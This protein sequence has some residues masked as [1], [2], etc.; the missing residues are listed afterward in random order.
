MPY[1]K[2]G[3]SHVTLPPSRIKRLVDGL[4]FSGPADPR[5]H[6]AD[7]QDARARSR[8]Q[9]QAGAPRWRR[10]HPK[11]R[12]AEAVLDRRR[13]LDQCKKTEMVAADAWHR[14][15]LDEAPHAGIRQKTGGRYRGA[16]NHQIPE[17]AAGC[18]CQQ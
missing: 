12:A 18:R 4:S 8:E 11:S 3:N 6:A 7:E 5:K 16:R 17:S 9:A 13:R 15:K 1:E 10:G 14:R 2:E